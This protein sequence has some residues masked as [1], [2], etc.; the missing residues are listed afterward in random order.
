MSIQRLFKLA[1]YFRIKYAAP[2]S[3]HA[4]DGLLGKVH[5]AFAI[6][7]DN[8]QDIWISDSWQLIEK[9]NN[10]FHYRLS[11]D[12][13]FIIDAYQIKEDNKLSHEY[14]VTQSDGIP[15]FLSLK[16]IV[17]KYKKHLTNKKKLKQTT[18]VK[19]KDNK[20]DENTGLNTQ[21]YDLQSL[22][23]WSS[24]EAEIK[25]KNLIVEDDYGIK[26][27]VELDSLF[28]FVSNEFSNTYIFINGKQTSLN[29]LR[30]R[31]NNNDIEKDIIP[32]IIDK[33]LDNFSSNWR[34]VKTMGSKEYWFKDLLDDESLD[35]GTELIRS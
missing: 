11:L 16:N 25:I 5:A 12:D 35:E 1:N 3:L 28:D 20:L 26:Q 27:N 9:T 31:F 15:Q 30:N 34:S 21:N 24:G 13:N 8:D 14:S 19:N 17:E 10:N 7:R 4:I 6:N 29:I 23:L 22:K 18:Q 33:F 2:V 32:N